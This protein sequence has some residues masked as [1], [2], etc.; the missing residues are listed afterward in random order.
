MVGYLLLLV[1][2]LASSAAIVRIIL[3]DRFDQDIEQQLARQSEELRVLAAG[4]DPD[5]GEPFGTDVES[6]LDTFLRRNVPAIDETLFTIL[7]GEPE[8]YSPQDV[9][10]QLLDD[11]P[12]VEHWSQITTPMR[13]D[14]GT[15]AGRVRTLA[16]PLVVEGVTGGTLVI[17]WFVDPG[18][19]D[20]DQTVQAIGLVGIAAFV[21]AIA[22][23]WGLA[24]RVLSP[25]AELTDTARRINETDLAARI[26][27]DGHDELAH[28]GHT[29]NDMLDRLEDSFDSQRAFLNDVAHELRT[30]ITIARGHLELMG[31]DPVEHER[32][33]NMVTTELER[34]SRYVDDLLVLA[35][36]EQPDFL[37]TR[38][39]DLGELVLDVLARLEAINDRAWRLDATPDPGE[40]ITD[41]DR[42]RIV[43]AVLAL[44]TNAV[45]HTSPGDVIGLGVAVDGDTCRLWI[46]DTGPGVPAELRDEL[47]QRNTRAADSR[48][49]R[50]EGT[51]LGLAIVAAI[52]EAH[53]GTVHAEETPGG[54]ATFVLSLDRLARDATTRAML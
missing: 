16:V 31:E 43:Q 38:P 24:A 21:V 41:G 1:L 49:R 15:S 28:L 5:T 47:F 14:Y 3:I 33:V 12:L 26:P 40:A 50:P 29:F 17:A 53:G 37:R 19:H 9:P 8:A 45:Q 35:R 20:I 18:L 54:G 34:M 44:A 27:V 52:A 22:L 51:G 13:A 39:V 10:A 32:T 7:D 2:A 30:P 25:V 42:D 46:R 4:R 6:I 48:H 11:R 23:A 36:A